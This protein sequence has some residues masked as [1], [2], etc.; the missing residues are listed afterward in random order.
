MWKSSRGLNTF[1][2]HCMSMLH[3]NLSLLRCQINILNG[4]CSLCFYHRAPLGEEN[5]L[6]S[7]RLLRPRNTMKHYFCNDFYV[8]PLFRWGKHTKLQKTIK[9]KKYFE[10]LLLQWLLCWVP[11]WS[12]LSQNYIF[13]NQFELSGANMVLKCMS[14]G[15]GIYLIENV[16]GADPQTP[17]GF[18]YFHTSMSLCVLHSPMLNLHSSRGC[19]S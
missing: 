19:W 14:T 9:T 12:I 18:Y 13:Q 15:N 1:A 11:F 2:S 5:T 10:T 17:S 6:N 3:H 4:Y 7:R 8:G 16:L